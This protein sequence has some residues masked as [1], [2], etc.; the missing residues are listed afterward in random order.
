VPA[1]LL[2]D[3]AVIDDPYPFFRRLVEQEPVWPVPGTSIVI[4]SSFDAVAEAT[5]RVD[6]F[7]SNLRSI[8]Y[9]T[10]GG[11]PEVMPFATEEDGV[12]ALATA[13]PPLHT[14][15]RG[16]VFPELISRR[17]DALRSDIEQMAEVHIGRAIERS[18][19]D[20][21][22]EIANAI[23]I[24][25]VSKLIGFE[26]VDP[27]QLLAAGF[28]STDMLAA[29]E[30]MSEILGSMERTAEVLWSIGDQ[31]ERAR[32]RRDASGILGVIAGAV[33]DGDIDSSQGL[34]IMYTLLSAGGESTTS[35]L[36]NA[37]HLLA[38]MPD[39][40]RRL[41]DDLD[42]VN[43]FIEEA[44]RL[45]S[46]FRHHLRHVPATT[47][48]RGVR[49]PAGSTMLLLWGAANRDPSKYERPDE[50]VL[51]RPRPRHHLAFGRGIHHCVGAPLA[52]LEAQIVLSRFLERTK[53]FTLDPDRQPQ[54]V[55]SLMV[56]R[57]RELPLLVTPDVTSR[58]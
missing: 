14:V 8:L 34:T 1:D 31:L 45:E 41:R 58:A 40:Q 51:D 36:G 53:S 26:N 32:S 46:P 43:P 24:R 2:L 23:P 37:I 16:K 5:N 10:D 20:V 47:D 22:D 30:P 17:M 35:L 38:V 50:V 3:P 15:H 29:T 25:V 33:N 9:R 6:D 42:L 52:R 48:L 18:R 49:I 55:R 44:L 4:V 28:E 54:R 19:V 13:D 12:D 27:D 11:T 7:S 56:R 39:L 57:F 21:M